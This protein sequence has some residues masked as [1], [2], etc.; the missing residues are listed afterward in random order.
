MTSL[1]ALSK[2]KLTDLQSAL[3][4]EYRQEQAKGLLLNMSR[5]K[6]APDQLDLSMDLLRLPD[7]CILEDDTDRKSVV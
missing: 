5:G 4:N 7:S 2:D 6:P 3:W 1:R